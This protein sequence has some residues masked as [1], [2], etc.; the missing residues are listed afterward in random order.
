MTRSFG[1]QEC[2]RGGMPQTI[3]DGRRR[4]AGG[5]RKTGLSRPCVSTECTWTLPVPALQHGSMAA[6]H[7][8][9]AHSVAV[10]PLQSRV[11]RRKILLDTLFL[12][13]PWHAIESR[14]CQP[15]LPG[16]TV[17][18]HARALAQDGRLLRTQAAARRHPLTWPGPLSRLQ[19]VARL[20]FRHPVT[21]DSCSSFVVVAVSRHQDP[22]RLGCCSFGYDGATLLKAESSPP[23]P[24]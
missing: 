1:R 22:F 19:L 3:A 21:K 24:S 12:L 16:C 20:Y 18:T 8:S 23:F 15:K 5:R 4:C 14:P 9:T 6:L 13:R 2:H 7:V 10:K 11:G 17:H